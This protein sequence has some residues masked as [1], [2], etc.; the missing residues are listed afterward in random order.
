MLRP[1]SVFL[2]SGV[3][4]LS[5]DRERVIYPTMTS[6][7]TLAW[8]AEAGTITASD[9]VFAALPLALRP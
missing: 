3:Q 2:R 4:T 5:T 8:T 9:R 6:D 1:Q 7:P